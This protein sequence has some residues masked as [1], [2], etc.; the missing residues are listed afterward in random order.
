MR[1]SV[2]V[3]NGSKVNRGHNARSKDSIYNQYHLDK[4]GE[5]EIWRDIDVKDA[6]HFLFDSSV[7]EFNSKQRD[8]KRIINDY[9]EK[10]ENGKDK[11]NAPKPVYELIVAVGNMEEHIQ[12]EE[13][14]KKI[15][16]E[17]YKDWDKR[18]PNLFLIGAYYHNDE[19]GVMH[20]HLDY[21][22]IAHSEKRGLKVY[23]GLNQAL[24]EQGFIN[25]KFSNTPQMR[26]E[27]SEQKVLM[28]ICNSY[29]I[30]TENKECGKRKH[31]EKEE[32][33][34][35]KKIENLDSEIENKNGELI[36]KDFNIMILKDEEKQLIQN[37]QI[38]KKEQEE[39]LEENKKLSFKSKILGQQLLNLCENSKRVRE[40]CTK[41]FNN[42]LQSWQGMDNTGTAE[43]L[44]SMFQEEELII[45]SHKKLE[46]EINNI[47][48]KKKDNDVD[49][50][51]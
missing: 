30:E 50:E 7:N 42:M 47:V 15:L 9:Y 28:D 27:K 34:R 26:W 14:N 8:K 24:N 3:H 11:K 2:S 25:D 22:S 45:D 29:N 37:N 44:K 10:I 35:M 33:I 17:Y 23:N 19:R 36:N 32:Y 38:Y 4:N 21:I 6:Y 48:E 49:F 20:L 39:I 18:N 43:K 40:N 41:F 31:F 12:D 5:F 13:L 46:N 51:L 16:K 1:Y